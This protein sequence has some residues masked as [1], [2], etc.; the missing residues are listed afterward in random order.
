MNLENFDDEKYYRNT[1]KAKK[2]RRTRRKDLK[3]TKIPKSK[4]KSEDYHLIARRKRAQ[5]LSNWYY[6]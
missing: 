3:S 1:M 6:K 4:P 2:F 5:K